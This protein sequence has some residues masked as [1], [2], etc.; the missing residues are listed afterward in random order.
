MLADIV[1]TMLLYKRPTIGV[2]LDISVS[3]TAGVQEFFQPG[4]YIMHNMGPNIAYMRMY[5]EGGSSKATVKDMPLFPY[6]S[7]DMSSVCIQIGLRDVKNI[8]A[9]GGLGGGHPPDFKFLHHI[10]A[11]GETATLRA[12]RMT[13][14]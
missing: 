2:S 4:L 6:G 3:A 11:T 9:N 8:P 13:K 7:Q 5:Q 1:N 10:C 12:T 14:D